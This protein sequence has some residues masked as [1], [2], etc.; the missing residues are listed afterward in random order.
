MNKK[1]LPRHTSHRG[2][3]TVPPLPPSSSFLRHFPRRLARLQFLFCLRLC[4]PS[5]SS[6]KR[7]FSPLFFSFALGG[8]GGRSVVAR[9]AGEGR[10]FLPFSEASPSVGFKRVREGRGGVPS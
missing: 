10:P 4:R 2:S 1:K 8:V 5:S 3:F 9:S 7:L 6:A